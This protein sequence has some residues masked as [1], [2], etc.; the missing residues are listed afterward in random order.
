MAQP[1]KNIQPP[2]HERPFFRILVVFLIV[3]TVGLLSTY[4]IINRSRDGSSDAVTNTES[5]ANQNSAPA[6][7]DTRR[8][9]TPED[10]DH[11][12]VPNADED[13]MGTNPTLADSDRDGL[14]DFDEANIYR[15][16]PTRA[17]S[18]GDGHADGT[19][20]TQG[21]NPAGAGKLFDTIPPAET[22]TP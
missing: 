9:A 1:Q 18:D 15:T 14:T 12:G 21:F 7:F 17:D 13:R 20:V 10:T 3:L 11:D 6:N 19:E 5:G 22:S 16:D 2:L 4:F 8:G